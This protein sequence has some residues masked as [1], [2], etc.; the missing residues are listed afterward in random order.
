VPKAATSPTEA[1]PLV[2][3][4]TPCPLQRLVVV[5]Q[6]PDAPAGLLGDWAAARGADVEVVRAPEVDEWP[7]PRGAGAVVALGSEQSV[8]ASSAPWIAPQLRFLRAAHDAGVPV[9]GICFGAQALAAALG[10][11]ATRAPAPEI[12]WIEVAGADGY[13]GPWFA[14]HEDTFTLPPGAQELARSAACPHAFRI[15]RSVGLQ[16]HPE[17]T[18]AIV[19][20]WIRDGRDTLAAQRLDGEAINAR[21][22]GEADAH[23]ARSFALFD[24]IAAG[25]TEDRRTDVQSGEGG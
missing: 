16:F 18:P 19:A 21:T 8:H 14:W 2:A 25:W 6:Q 11:S 23:R 1:G 22:R 10:G 5:E 12:G 7:D 4:A 20:G 3:E 9:L 17:V 24:A 15:G 13:T